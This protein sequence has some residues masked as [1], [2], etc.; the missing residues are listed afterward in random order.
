[1]HGEKWLKG[2]TLFGLVCH[3]IRHRAQRNVLMCHGSPWDGDAYV[4]PDAPVDVRRR[5]VD[6]GCDIVFFGHSHYPV[7]WDK[8]GSRVVNPGSVGQPRNRRPGA[9]WAL[10]DT[11]ADEIELRC[12]AYDPEPVIAACRHHDPDIPYLRDVLTRT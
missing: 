4:Y 11:E 10:W 7:C 5:M 6:D 1:M 12:E 2:Q 8:V 3:E 9:H